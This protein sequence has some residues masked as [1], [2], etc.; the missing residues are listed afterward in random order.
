[1]LGGPARAPVLAQ[2]VLALGGRPVGAPTSRVL[3]IP[4]GIA[5]GVLLRIL[6]DSDTERVVA[7]PRVPSVKIKMS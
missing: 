3:Q 7:D 6:M 5:Q 2:R 1:M 4:G